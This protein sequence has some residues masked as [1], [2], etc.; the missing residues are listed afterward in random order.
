MSGPGGKRDT[1]DVIV[2]GG[3]VIGLSAAWALARENLRV[4]LVESGRVGA[5]ASWAAAGVT[6]PCS[7]NRHD[8]LAQLLRGGIAMFG[9]KV[10]E[11]EEATGVDVEYA[12][13]GA[14]KLLYTD[15]HVRMARSEVQACEPYEQEYGRPLFEVLSAEQA[16][17]IEPNLARDPLAVTHSRMSAQVRSSCLL[18]ALHSACLG[19][20]VRV[21]EGQPVCALVRDADRVIGVRT[22][23]ESYHAEHV[24][25]AAGAWSALIDER[26]AAL[27]PVY[28]VRGQIILLQQNLLPFSRIIQ[29]SKCYLVPRRDGRI[30][31]GATHEEQSG[32]DKSNTAEGLRDLLAQAT[33]MVPR[34]EQARVVGAWAGLRPGTLDNRPVIGT[35]ESCP[36]L[37]FATGHY[38]T[39]ICLTWITAEIVRDLVVR[40]RTGTDL[41]RCAPGREF[42]AARPSLAPE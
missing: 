30:L 21:L 6:N 42:G 40:G 7:W 33:G 28:P 11:L 29:R 19:A 1:S 9:Q 17:G 5:E 2:I 36:G 13:C 23:S 31:I 14:L 22:S 35:H 32:F 10:P 26:I 15:Q 18:R 39:G 12:R 3:G 4:T 41:E 34:L 25:L 8:S 20:G 24:V 37:I 38:R 27:A 16:A